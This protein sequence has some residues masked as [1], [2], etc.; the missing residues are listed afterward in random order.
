[1]PTT[2]FEKEGK[3]VVEIEDNGVGFEK[4][5]GDELKSIRDRLLLVKGN[6]QILSPRKPT[7]IQA[8]LGLKEN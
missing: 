3:I 8:E 7:L 2:L 5:F 6:V 1:M 4:T